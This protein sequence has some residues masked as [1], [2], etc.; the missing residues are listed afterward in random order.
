MNM[1]RLVFAIIAAYIAMS[2]IGI[3]SEMLFAEQLAGMKAIQR[4]GPDL[5]AHAVWMY[6]GY[7]IVTILFCYI[8]V[9]HHEGKGWMEGARFGLMIGLMMSGISM[10]MYAS[11]PFGGM[12]SLLGAVVGVII[13]V[14]GGIVTAVVYKTEG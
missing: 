8:Y 5:A 14:V 13:Y 7:F 12:E 4:V 9:Q 3:A 11:M 2:V 10:V 1:K 6:L